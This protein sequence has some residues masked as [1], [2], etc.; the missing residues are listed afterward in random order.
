MS[1]QSRAKIPGNGKR[2]SDGAESRR[3]Q[4]VIAERRA[5]RL[6]RLLF[7]G[8]AA[9]IAIVLVVVL[10]AVN[11]SRSDD[12]TAS[13]LPIIV[14][15]AQR[16]DV[17]ADGRI[18]GDPNA[19]VQVI[20]YG[21]YQCPACGV[22]GRDQERQ[23]V[24]EF[25]ATG[26]VRFEYRDFAFIGKESTAAAEASA[27][28]LEQDR[29][30]EYHA[31]LYSNQDGENKGA[32]HRSRLIEM[33][34]KVGLDEAQ[35]TSCIDSDRH[36]DAVS[37]SLAEGRERGVSSTPSFYVNGTLIIGA[38]YPAIRDAINKELATP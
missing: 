6:R 18:K 22:F 4:R 26:Q 38:N 14:P 21:D 32:F 29:F 1:S 9:G 31:I 7:F 30:W 24:D 36:E 28:A 3:A 11:S 12:G 19:P 17:P 15:A 16:A 20:E 2:G 8:G 33:A 5:A 34:G 35:F 27:C 25:V 37:A 23:L 13:S 10:I